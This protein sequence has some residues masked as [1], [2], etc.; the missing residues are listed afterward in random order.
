MK[1]GENKLC[2]SVRLALSL[3]VLAA[4]TYGTAAFA[5]DA[6]STTPAPAAD[7]AKSKTLET[8]TVTGSLIR[9]VDV[10]TASP[11]VTIDRAQIQAT[12]KATLGDLIQQLP[13]MTGGNVNPQTNNGGGG[14]GRACTVLDRRSLRGQRGYALPRAGMV[15]HRGG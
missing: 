4:S 14:R 11:V 5:Q 9:R 1:F 2:T 3:G 13:A 7:Q 15:A 8:V 6:Q 10:E 12:G